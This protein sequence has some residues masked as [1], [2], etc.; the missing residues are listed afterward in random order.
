[1]RGTISVDSTLGAGT[2]FTVTIPLESDPNSDE[3]TDMNQTSSLTLFSN[4]ERLIDSSVGHAQRARKTIH[5]CRT[6]TEAMIQAESTSGIIID[7]DALP[8]RTELME[9]LSAP[10]LRKKF[11]L[12]SFRFDTEP[13]R[14]LLDGVITKPISTAALI[15]ST[16]REAGLI[17]DS[18]QARSIGTVELTRKAKVL[19][20]EDL[21]TNQ[22]IAMAVFEMY[23]CTVVVANNGQEAFEKFKQ[24]RYDAIFM[25]CQMPI[26]DGYEATSLIRQHENEHNL[27]RTPVVAL[28]AGNS[29]DEMRRGLAAGMDQYLTKPFKMDEIRL[30]L[31]THGIHVPPAPTASSDSNDIA[32]TSESPYQTI[33]TLNMEAIGNIFSVEKQTGGGLLDKLVDGYREQMK[34]KLEMLESAAKREDVKMIYSSAH[35]IKS[36]SSNIGAEKVRLISAGIEKNA[37][38]GIAIN[39]A[40]DVADLEIANY[41]FLTAIS[42]LLNSD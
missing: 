35:A 4:N 41:D 30:A 15:E 31:V 21:E 16:V 14:S 11:L 38:A 29:G 25:D 24:S 20:A 33:K 40:R 23:G 10:S 12:C 13:Y 1:M 5:S 32:D 26:M 42:E 8:S 37:K 22:K 17:P 27:P 6:K 9:F 7:V 3:A 34:E 18:P 19:I 2:V 36:M 28:T 39:L